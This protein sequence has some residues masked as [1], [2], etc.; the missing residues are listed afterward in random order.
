MGK[1]FRGKGIHVQFGPTMHV[2]ADLVALFDFLHHPG[3]SQ[4]P[5]VP[6]ETGKGTIPL[7]YLIVR[8]GGDPYLSGEG[9]YETI[10]GVRS[11][12]VQACAKH[13]I[14]NEQEHSRK[15]SSS[16]VDDR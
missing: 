6:A 1:E 16:N 11:Q 13:Y 3:T 4:E 2:F 5:L 15:L 7:V 9:A 8:F 10:R 14:N 12:G